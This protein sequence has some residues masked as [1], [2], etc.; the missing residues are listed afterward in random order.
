MDFQ[1][2][3]NQDGRLRLRRRTLWVPGPDDPAVGY[4]Q[5]I[6]W[7]VDG[8]AG[9][10]S[11]NV[12]MG[13][14][15]NGEVDATSMGTELMADRFVL[16]ALAVR[17]VFVHAFR[18]WPVPLDHQ[19]VHD[20]CP[21]LGGHT[22]C[23]T[24]QLLGEHQPELHELLVRLVQ[25]GGPGF[26]WERLEGIYRDEFAP[27]LSPEA[28]AAREREEGA[29]LAEATARGAGLAQLASPQE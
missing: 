28:Y 25:P 11:L 4:A 15:R 18:P 23:Y 3:A 8:M 27:A 16:A 26:V 5:Q 7:V 21:A 19:D 24:Q 12:D 20:G 10:V 2:D 1:A 13:A 14:F 9:A 22:T 6:Q 29:R 17:G